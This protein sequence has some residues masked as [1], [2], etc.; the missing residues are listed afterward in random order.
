MI[1]D[2]LVRARIPQDVKDRAVAA[3]DKMGLSTSDV[4]RLVM[5]RVAEEGRLPFEVRTPNTTTIK[6]IAQLE[7]GK[8]ERFE[9]IDA[10]F[11]DLGI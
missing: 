8:G 9:N 2:A 1:A 5:M 11:K 6:S 10:L 3:L 7:N 4:I